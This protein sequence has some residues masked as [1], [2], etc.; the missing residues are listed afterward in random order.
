MHLLRIRSQATNDLNRLQLEPRTPCSPS[1]KLFAP[2]LGLSNVG[3]YQVHKNYHNLVHNWHP[4]LLTQFK[5]TAIF[6][7][8]TSSCCRPSLPPIQCLFAKYSENPPWLKCRE[9]LKCEK[10]FVVW[11]IGADQLLKES[12]AGISRDPSDPSKVES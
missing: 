2:A 4:M 12:E 5:A 11:E 6:P 1:A 10:T 9:C 3:N 8:S 7:T